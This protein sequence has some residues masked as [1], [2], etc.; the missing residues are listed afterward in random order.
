MT[1]ALTRI[2]SALAGRYE[3][4]RELG[5]GGMAIVYRAKD[6]RHWRPVAIKV[7]GADVATTVGAERFLREIEIAAS[8]THPNILPLI[9]SGALDDGRAYY[10]MPFIDG[11]SL[12][13]KLTRERQLPIEE[14]V[15]L[16]REAAD[17]LQYAHD[18][19]IVHRDI[20]PENILL[21]GGHAVVADFGVARAL[22]Q[23]GAATL[24][25]TGTAIGTPL[26]MSPEQAAADPS[27]DQRSDVYSLGVVLYEMLGGS[28]PHSGQTNQAIMARKMAGPP[29]SLR[30]IRPAITPALEQAVFKS[31]EVSAADRFSTARELSAA[32][33]SAV[34][35]TSTP[36]T[37]TPARARW[38]ALVAATLVVAGGAIAGWKIF[39]K[40]T[41]VDDHVVAVV[42]FRVSGVDT[43]ATRY[44]LGMLELLHSSFTGEGG[45]R[46]VSPASVLSVWRGMVKS[47]AE[48]LPEDRALALARR[49]GAGRLLTGSIVGVPNGLVIDATLAPVDGGAPIN[50]RAEGHPDS[51][52]ALVDRIVGDLLV[53]S[54]IGA[55]RPQLGTL[56]SPSLPALKA[57]L[58]GQSAYR[59][60][61]FAEAAKLYNAAIKLDSGFALAGLGLAKTSGWG[62]SG[63]SYEDGMRVAWLG[64][65][66]LG[67]R[68][69]TQFELYGGANYP[70]PSYAKDATGVVERLVQL[71]PDDPEAWH[72]Y[73][74]HFFHYGRM[75]DIPDAVNLARRGFERAVF[76]DSGFSAPVAH[77]IDLGGLTGD[78][79]AVRR[80]YTLRSRQADA[81]GVPVRF[82]Q[83]W[84]TAV[85][86]NDSAAIDS[87]HQAVR[88]GANVGTAMTFA[89]T[90]A[91]DLP[92]AELAL[93]RQW[94][95][96][97][98]GQLF[99]AVSLVQLYESMGRPSSA[100][101][102]L[103][104][105]ADR[106]F[107][108]M[109]QSLRVIGAIYSQLDTIA[110]AKAALALERFA[111]TTT[112]T[113]LGGRRIRWVSLALAQLWRASRGGY[114][115][116]DRVASLGKT[117]VGSPQSA[118]YGLEEE[119]LIAVLEAVSESQ[120]KGATAALD[121]L[122]SITARGP[123]HYSFARGLA[124]LTAARLLE[125]KG[126]NVAA[127]RAVRRSPYDFA[128]ASNLQGVIA[129]EEGRLAAMTGDRAGAIAAY[130]RY[131][132][133]R[134][135]A[136]PPLVAERERV[137]AELQ[138]LTDAR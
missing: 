1:D 8:L 12:R 27:V 121:R 81:G 42:P 68:D 66:R 54:S 64:R 100:E 72:E 41:P 97:S 117:L 135:N 34:T 62:A 75:L 73:G 45:L 14:A 89:A 109:S 126:D 50:A 6:L 71:A 127:L 22:T 93:E 3:I 130:Q 53:R 44:R 40:T 26:Y 138:R 23:G 116:L 87:L 7:M 24:T 47:P 105:M 52:L 74:D 115:S 57:Y 88:D 112:A 137:R 63:A 5:R 30:A 55:A 99:A 107:W 43:S 46:S 98:T 16:A 51:V 102:V 92:M 77:L 110:G 65:D 36:S 113:D 86:F 56:T 101:R 95:E 49:V 136:E 48:D 35:P 122:D 38:P 131:L 25:Q 17:A 67:P 33:A 114:S 20:K 60:G 134:A 18:R 125:E 83:R 103:G 106:R 118:N 133:F 15:R 28:A 85:T 37:P 29:P 39:G 58:D 128:N 21:G 59:S 32:L 70:G 11:E 9:D 76:L 90:E 124:A 2:S 96:R 104:E 120:R 31:I 4:E 129:R 119:L 19:G 94:R 78:T 79:A 84:R 91:L 10:I 69:R 61:E 13:Q 132:R 111:D 80:Y 82:L 108:H 123:T